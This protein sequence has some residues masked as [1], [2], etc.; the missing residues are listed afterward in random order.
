MPRARRTQPPR[1]SI[2]KQGAPEAE[3]E[4]WGQE[5]KEG[6]RRADVLSLP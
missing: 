5:G 3:I 1:K 4:A 6:R 2:E